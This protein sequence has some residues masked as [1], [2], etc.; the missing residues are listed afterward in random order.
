MQISHLICIFSGVVGSLVIVVSLVGFAVLSLAI[1]ILFGS[2]MFE[3][4]IDSTSSVV[5]IGFVVSPVGLQQCFS[6]FSARFSLVGGFAAS[7][8]GL[9][10]IISGS[11]LWC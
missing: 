7:M 9:V 3:L 1:M 8:G 4:I 2:S 11:V 5:R 10:L 6:A